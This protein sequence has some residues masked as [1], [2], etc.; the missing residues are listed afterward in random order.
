MKL[1][2]FLIVATLYQ[3][4]AQAEILD[5]VQQ[6]VDAFNKRDIER[7]TENVSADFTWYSVSNDSSWVELSGKENFRHAMI[8]YF[9]SRNYQITSSIHSYI[10][11]GNRLS[12]EEWV[13]HR[14]AAWQIVRS[15]A[16][17][18]YQMNDG[19]IERAW[20]FVE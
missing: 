11:S 17:A 3:L 12:F 2:L 9:E 13:E 10:I 15:S 6:Q 1:S 16:L 20:Y 14:N 19:K 18:I 8:S 7:L 5:L 4:T